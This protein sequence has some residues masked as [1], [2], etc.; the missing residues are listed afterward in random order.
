MLRLS[1]EDSAPPLPVAYSTT[2]SVIHPVAQ[3]ISQDCFSCRYQEQFIASS[4]WGR[5]WV[6][7][8][9]WEMNILG[10]WGRI[11]CGIWR[12]RLSV[13]LPHPPSA[14]LCPWPYSLLMW[15]VPFHLW[16]YNHWQRKLSKPHIKR[17]V[18]FT[19]Y[20]YPRKGLGS[21]CLSS[22]WAPGLIPSVNKMTHCDRASPG[23]TLSPEATAQGS[24]AE[25]S[26]GN[27]Y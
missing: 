1:P 20:P 25:K 26:D 10:S 27:T 3:W 16:G 7:S 12:N 22:V 8:Q 24:L 13:L 4:S 23:Y 2:C 18:F 9:N 21:A 17:E 14:S 5:H 19:R 6:S 15:T 11:E